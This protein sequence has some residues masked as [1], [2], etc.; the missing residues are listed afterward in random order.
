LRYAL[1]LREDGILW[2]D[3][4]V[5][6]LG[7]NHFLVTMTT[8]NAALV[9]RWMNKLLQLQWSDLDVQLTSVSDHWASLAIAGPK[10]RQ[11][12]QALNPDFDCDRDAFPF[13]SVRAGKLDGQI[14]CRVFSVSF[15]GELSY[16]I[17]VPSG[18]ASLLFQR[19]VERGA[20][21]GITP[22]GL[23]ALDVLRIEKGHLSIGT[24]IDG[25]TTPADLGL[26]RMVSAD[27]AFVG[28]SLL[29]RPRLQ[30]DDRL[31]LVGLRPADDHSAIPLAAMLC[32][33]PWQAGSRLA[34]QGKLTASIHSPTL[35]QPIALALLQN[36]HRRLDEK[37]WAVSPLAQ[38]SV[39]VV[40]SSSCAVDPEGRRVHD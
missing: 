22:Y 31:Q 4:T 10:S 7:D 26:A 13:A 3:G 40:V 9:W 16:E 28:S 1:M 17:N 24:E 19:V 27:K 18:Y 25:R 2:D 14:P 33:R 36:G 15:S 30:R 29:R 34:A 21:L 39:E 38:Q 11:L 35:D 8:A 32:E 37:I 5:A 12:L 6:R 20:S 23:E